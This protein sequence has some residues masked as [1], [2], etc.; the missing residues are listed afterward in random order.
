MTCEERLRAPLLSN[1]EKR[2]LKGDLIALCSFLC[3]GSEGAH[4]SSVVSSDRTCGNGSKLHQGGIQT[5]H[6]K[7]SFTVMVVIHKLP[8]EVVDVLNQIMF[9][10]HMVN[11]LNDIF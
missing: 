4:L 1:L 7:N 11:D 8:R 6:R 3:K 9:K 2:R 5:G 10:K